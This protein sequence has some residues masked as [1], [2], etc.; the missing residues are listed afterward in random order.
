MHV[1]R[2][3]RRESESAQC[4]RFVRAGESVSWQGFVGN[5]L[6]EVI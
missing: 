5:P 2:R 1:K 6:P 3:E 4:H